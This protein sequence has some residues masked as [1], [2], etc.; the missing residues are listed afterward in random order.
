MLSEESPACRL[1]ASHQTIQPHDHHSDDEVWDPMQIAP[2]SSRFEL[3]FTT[4][5]SPQVLAEGA[6]RQEIGFS[7]K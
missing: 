3:K 4:L 2:P 7:I 5:T 6:V 1:R